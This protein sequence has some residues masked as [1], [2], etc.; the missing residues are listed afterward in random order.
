MRVPRFFADPGEISGGQV[1]LAGEEARHALKVLRL[2]V[3]DRIA[4]LDN[5]G[6]EYQAE[7]TD[8]GPDGLT[9]RV[10]GQEARRTEPR[11]A[12]TIAQ[13]I[14]KGDRFETVVQ[15]GTEVGAVRFVPLFTE[16]TIVELTGAKAAA[17]TERWRRVAKEAAKQAGRAVVPEITNP[18][19]LGHLL[20]WWAGRGQVLVLWEDERTLGLRE[21]IKPLPDTEETHELLMVIGPEG[22]LSEREVGELRLAGA[23]T[24]TLGPRILRTETA[25]PVALA[26]ALLLAGDLG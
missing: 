5:R 16:R 6:V 17:R 26:C 22:G 8:S 25:G 13:G 1:R 7:I 9:G 15:K 11:L 2:S 14:P 23:D 21:L 12:V 18:V 20:E 24:V 19:N 4:V 3:G 10:L